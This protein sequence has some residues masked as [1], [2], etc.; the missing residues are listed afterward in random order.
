MDRSIVPVL[1]TK[2]A[3]AARQLHIRGPALL[4]LRSSKF[5]FAVQ[6]RDPYRD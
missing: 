1:P 5:A 2:Y 3:A 6:G 4:A